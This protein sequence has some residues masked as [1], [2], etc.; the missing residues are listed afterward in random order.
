MCCTF[1]I[2][3]HTR[4][5]DLPHP[6]PPTHHQHPSFCFLYLVGTILFFQQEEAP[7]LITA[8]T[9]TKDLSLSLSTPLSPRSTIHCIREQW[10]SIDSISHGR[11]TRS[12]IGFSRLPET[13]LRPLQTRPTHSSHP[14]L[15][16]LLRAPPTPQVLKPRP[17]LL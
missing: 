5:K 7:P 10:T 4:T 11:L 16:L 3:T 15:S 17:V 9:R 12:W 1:F 8:P 6:H 2:T 14:C 13:R